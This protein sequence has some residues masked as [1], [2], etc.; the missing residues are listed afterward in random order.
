MKLDSGTRLGPYEVQEPI[1]AGG[2]GEVYRARDTQLNR[3]VALKVL[4][5]LFAQDTDRLARFKREAQVLASLNHPNIAAIY[6]FEGASDIQALVLEYVEGPTLSERIGPHG[7]PLDDALPIAR[8]VADALENAHEQNIVHRDL[9]PAN[10][11]L[12]PDGTVKVLDFGL[13][14]ALEPPPAVASE[15][16]ILP[17]ITSP[18]MTRAGM[19]LGTAAYMSPEQAKGQLADKRSDVWAFGSMLYEMLTGRR[20]FEGDDV[21]QT[22]ALVLTKEPD[23]S[24]L[25]PHTPLPVRRLLRRCLEKDR[26]KRLADIADARLE[27]DEALRSTPAEPPADHAALGAPGGIRARLSGWRAVF[28]W[29]AAGLLVGVGAATSFVMW[30]LPR[31]APNQAPL[32]FVVLP[33]DEHEFFVGRR[34]LSVSP[35]GRRLAF[36]TGATPSEARLWVR[37]LDSFTALPI[38]GTDAASRPVWSPDGR[39]VAFS[40]GPSG[41]GRLR[42]VDIPGGQPRTLA[43]EGAPGAWSPQ[44]VI[45]FTGRDRRIHRVSDTGGDP[46]PVTEL[47]T[48]QQEFL[49][50]PGFFLSDGRR[51]VFGARTMDGSRS[52][53][54]VASLDSTVRTRLLDGVSSPQFANGHIFYQRDGLVMVQRFDEASGRLDGSPVPV[55]QNVDYDAPSWEAAFS[56]SSNGVLVYRPAEG[57]DSNTMTWFGQDGRPLATVPIDGVHQISRRPELSPDGRRLALTRIEGRQR[58]V[59]IVDLDRNVPSKVTFDGASEGPVWSRPDGARI[60]FTST[61][62]GAGDLYQ[63]DSG[64]GGA[65]ELLYESPVA[66]RAQAISPDGKVLLFGQVPQGN[67]EIWALPLIGARE[68]IPIVRTGF[69]AGN[70]VFSPDGRWFAYCEGDSGADQVYIQPYPPTGRRIRVSPTSGSSPQWSADGRT[71]VYV[72]A[73]NRVMVADLA[74]NGGSLRV[75]VPRELFQVRSTFAHRSVLLDAERSRLL[76]LTSPGERPPIH[77]V[78]N[79]V[80]EVEQALRRRADP[81]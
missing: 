54:Y 23:W 39:A 45:L 69:P 80:L 30:R 31:A 67:P 35:D 57:A 5:A 77:V 81:Q 50:E 18:A 15:A 17:T 32:R 8:Q 22:L 40:A 48:A 10:V 58:N 6:G 25:P 41:L 9:K 26:R 61:R 64:G 65:E 2:M 66:K 51:F 36:V 38:E 78:V 68:P 76:S 70:A 20:V 24:A 74:P 59:W 49:H 19:I 44:G 62:K 43:D 16:D 73:G 21:L 27:I 79:W 34:F 53:V 52:A 46:A 11:K 28:A 4:P 75:G 1:G 12:R 13:A 56:V 42:L 33:P 29:S 37:P 60:V 14:R 63:R 55:I 47:D 72:T 3:H 71:V 7:I